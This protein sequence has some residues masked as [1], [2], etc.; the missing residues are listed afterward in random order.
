MPCGMRSVS[1]METGPG[2]DHR[3]TGEGAGDMGGAAQESA[4]VAVA[5]D[6]TEER[7]MK[8]GTVRR[9]RTVFKSQ[10]SNEY[11]ALTKEGNYESIGSL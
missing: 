3:G 8:T 1:G 6:E 5:R 11:D 10:G 2:Q 4:A 7:E 9:F